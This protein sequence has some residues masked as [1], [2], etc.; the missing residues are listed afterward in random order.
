MARVCRLAAE[1]D[2]CRVELK[3]RVDNPSQRFYEVIGMAMT[4][5]VPYTIRDQALRDLAAED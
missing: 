2:C 3:V 4:E 5:E 1:R